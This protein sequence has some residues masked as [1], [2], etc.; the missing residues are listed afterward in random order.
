MAIMEKD[1]IAKPI[2]GASVEL[3]KLVAGPSK[4]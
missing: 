3:L 2:I 4:P 1:E